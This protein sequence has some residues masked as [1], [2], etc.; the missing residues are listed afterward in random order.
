[1]SINFVYVLIHQS[2]WTMDEWAG[3]RVGPVFHYVCVLNARKCHIGVI[4]FFGNNIFF[5]KIYE[6]WRKFSWY[7]MTLEMT[8]TVL[9]FF[10]FPYTFKLKNLFHLLSC[11]HFFLPLRFLCVVFLYKFNL[12]LITQHYTCQIITTKKRFGC[13]TRLE[14][15]RYL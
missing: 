12:L 10:V 9:L 11:R 7:G 14:H 8:M 1:M 15:A 3:V 2:I 13:V 6:K 4:F 5:F